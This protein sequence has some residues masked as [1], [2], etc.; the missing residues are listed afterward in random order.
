MVLPK[1]TCGERFRKLVHSSIIFQHIVS[2]LDTLNSTKN[3][4]EIYAHT[5]R[6]LPLQDNCQTDYHMADIFSIII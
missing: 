3:S 5:H 2:V 4:Q 1:L 6:S